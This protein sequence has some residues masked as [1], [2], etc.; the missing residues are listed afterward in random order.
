MNPAKKI[1]STIVALVLVFCAMPFSQAQAANDPE[2]L[3]YV[4]DL[5]NG[6][7]VET[8]ITIYPGVTRNQSTSAI[9]SS[10]FKNNGVWI[11]TVSLKAYFTYNGITAGVTEYSKSL[12]SGWSY[13]NHKI[14]TT[15]VS[16]SSG[17]TATLTA[18]LKDFPINVPVRLSLHCAPNGAI[19]RG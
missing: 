7:T 10:E 11:A 15:N 3:F 14:T 19:T 13:T 16:S 18:T 1:C 8:T 9:S 12:A 17:G 2:T 4:E 5:G 6:I